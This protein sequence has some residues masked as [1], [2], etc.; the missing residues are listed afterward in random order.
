MCGGE[1]KKYRRVG[2]ECRLTRCPILIWSVCWSPFKMVYFFLCFWSSLSDVSCRFT[3]A[4]NLFICP[5]KLRLAPI[6]LLAN[7]TFV[8][9]YL[10]RIK[11]KILLFLIQYLHPINYWISHYQT[12]VC[13]GLI[14][15]K[16]SVYWRK[17]KQVTNC[18]LLKFLIESYVLLTYCWVNKY[19]TCPNTDLLCFLRCLKRLRNSLCLLLQFLFW[20]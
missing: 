16:L 14:F 10:F 1:N 20:E 11:I 6:I 3:L 19:A 4:G 5:Q 2:N 8:R 15:L 9:G 12:G 7:H 18:D 13:S 17:R